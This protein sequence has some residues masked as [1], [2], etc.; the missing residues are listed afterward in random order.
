[1]KS[2]PLSIP[3]ISKRQ[4]F[5]LAVLFITAGFFVSQMYA[6]NIKGLVVGVVLSFLTV[7]SMFL[8]LRS[9]IKGSFYYPILILPFLYT[10]SFN[11]FGNLIP[12]RILS[13]IIITALYAFGLYSLYLSHNIFALSSIRTINLLRSARGVSFVIT[14]IVLFFFLNVIFSLHLFVLNTTI[15]VFTIVFC[16]NFQSFWTYILD[17]NMIKEIILYSFYCSLAL[18]EL[19]L[20]LVVWPISAT[21]YSIFL[22]GMFY[23]YSGLSHAWLEK[24]LFKGVFWEYLWV[25]FIVI[26]I[27]IRFAEWGI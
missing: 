26:L 7:L 2:F 13:K 25:G 3:S 18:A 4:K 21:I 23:T 14:L 19:S 17:K 12:P 6:L 27:L 8:I 9:D 16:L 10:L 20:I 5:V 11:L 15:L 22:T 24:R 1:M